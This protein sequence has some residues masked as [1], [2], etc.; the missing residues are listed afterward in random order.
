MKNFNAKNIG[1]TNEPTTPDVALVDG[2][3]HSFFIDLQVSIPKAGVERLFHCLK[4]SMKCL[5]S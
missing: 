5:A 3:D 1:D 2:G 4:G